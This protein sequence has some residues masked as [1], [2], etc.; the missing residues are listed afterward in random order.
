MSAASA[1]ARSAPSSARRYSGRIKVVPSDGKGTY[2]FVGIDSLM[3]DDGRDHDLSGTH[4]VFIHQD[5]CPTGSKFQPGQEYGFEVEVDP[6][7]AGAFRAVN[8]S[9]VLHV[10]AVPTDGSSAV[11]GLALF[12]DRPTT[13]LAL[14]PGRAPK[15]A[16]AKLVSAETVAQVG[17]NEPLKGIPPDDFTAVPR[18]HTE[19]EI[20]AVMSAYLHQQYPNLQAVGLTYEVVGFDKKAQDALVAETSGLYKDQGMHQQITHLNEEYCSFQETRRLLSWIVEQKLLAEGSQVS[21][22]VLGSVVRL[23]ETIKTVSGKEGLVTAAQQV[24]TFMLAHDLMRANTVLPIDRL[25]DLAAAVPV[26]YFSRERNY[27]DMGAISLGVSYACELFPGNNRW[28]AFH[29]MYNRRERSM[30]TYKGDMVPPHIMRIMKEA[31]GVFDHVVVMTP[32]HDVAGQDWETFTWA[33]SIDP[34]VVGFKKGLPVFFILGRFSDSGVF[35]LL[36]ELVAD[37]VEFLRAN[38]EK[39]NGFDNRGDAV[40]WI[41]WTT[42]NSLMYNHRISGQRQLHVELKQVVDNLLQAFEAGRLFDWLRNEWS[43]EAPKLPANK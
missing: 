40:P 6:K 36:H 23:T 38:K 3:R 2:A 1:A 17:K 33:R 18:P 42:G 14:V 4:D 9:P 28:A 8:V 13:A 39:L 20:A 5:D 37:T 24:V 34:Y 31:Q 19:A 26:W 7:R 30:M 15:Q 16:H 27:S 21:P 41:S 43:P 12:S 22:A 32:Y 29:Q 25:P 11:P 35:P 10:A